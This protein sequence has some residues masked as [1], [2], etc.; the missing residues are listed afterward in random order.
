Q[1][2]AVVSAVADLFGRKRLVFIAGPCVIESEALCMQVAEHVAEV[3]TK[4]GVGYIFKAS[5]DKANRT[6][7][8]GFRGPGAQE[9][10]AILQRVRERVGVPV[11]TDVHHPEQAAVAAEAVDVLQIPA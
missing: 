4:H 1:G 6:S 11:L 10:L 5:Y 9:G 8:A 2:S 3:T 7:S